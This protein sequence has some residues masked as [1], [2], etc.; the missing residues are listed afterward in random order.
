MADRVVLSA[1]YPFL[2][3]LI[4]LLVGLTVGKAWE[5][6]KLR[7]GRLIDRR[8]VPESLHYIVGLN[9]LVTRSN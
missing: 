7:A 3:A 6:Y 1:Y 2:A 9:F 5:R 4:A 8:R